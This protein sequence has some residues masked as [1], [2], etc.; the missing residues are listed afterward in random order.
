MKSNFENYILF[1]LMRNPHEELSSGFIADCPDDPEL[2]SSIHFGD[3][4]FSNI[5]TKYLTKAKYTRV[6]SSS[7][8]AY[9]PLGRLVYNQDNYVFCIES[10]AKP[11]NIFSVS[12][13]IA[14]THFYSN[15]KMN[16][17]LTRYLSQIDYS[18]YSE[19]IE[20]KARS[21]EKS[22]IPDFPFNEIEINENG[23]FCNSEGA[24]YKVFFDYKGGKDGI[25]GLV[26]TNTWSIF[27]Y[28]GLVPEL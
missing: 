20:A 7:P 12:S 4:R 19:F 8:G 28:F 26:K 13:R 10:Q 11:K 1:D 3:K 5:V 21:L 14:T 18:D 6:S 25:I 23:V 27:S 22:S 17:G 9:T 15:S 2:F 16:N 24:R